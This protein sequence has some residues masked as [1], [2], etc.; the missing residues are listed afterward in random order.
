MKRC[1][2]F[3]SLAFVL[4]F[5]SCSPSGY[6]FDGKKL[7]QV[8]VSDISELY[9]TYKLTKPEQQQLANQVKSEALLNEITTY[10]NEAQ[11]PD[12]V[13]SLQKRLQVRPSLMKY[14][15]YKVATVGTKTIVS[16]PAEKN[17]HMPQGFV[18]SSPMYMI[19]ASNVVISK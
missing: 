1:V 13:N 11:W 2:C 3:L 5:A 4:F 17:R 19:F 9:S 7:Q 6:M 18:P 16:V 15:F 8:T 10:S 14:H 12:A